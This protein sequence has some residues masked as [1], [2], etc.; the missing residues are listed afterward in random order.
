MASARCARH[1]ST[2]E[3]PWK[4]AAK[5]KSGASA[6]KNEDT[7]GGR[8]KGAGARN[9]EEGS[10][11][12]LDD[13]RAWAAQRFRG[14]VHDSGA[15]GAGNGSGASASAGAP[16]AS[17]E[18][19]TEAGTDPE[20]EPVKLSYGTDGALIRPREPHPAE[21]C[22]SGCR[23]CVW[24]QYWEAS[25]LYEQAVANGNNDGNVDDPSDDRSSAAV[26]P[27]KDSHFLINHFR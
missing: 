18:P 20:P 17:G 19:L 24:I 11:L 4:T 5:A 23:S 22:G 12:S 10:K 6:Q 25:N 14:A 1:A 21:C 7:A 2:Y 16:A 9:A 26:K 27:A 3:P 8:A 13:R 15:S